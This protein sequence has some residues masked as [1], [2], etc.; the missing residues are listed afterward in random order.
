M[1]SEDQLH[2][3]QSDGD[4]GRIQRR[5]TLSLD[6]S[7]LSP[8]SELLARVFTA[9][10]TIKGL[11]DDNVFDSRTDGIHGFSD[12]QILASE[13]DLN[14]SIT[15]SDG[16]FNAVPPRKGRSRAAS[17]FRPP[18]RDQLYERN[19]HEWT[20]SGNNSQI[21]EFMRIKKINKRKSNDLYRASFAL[22]KNDNSHVVDINEMTTKTLP[23]STPTFLNRLNPFK[24][25]ESRKQSLTPDRLDIDR[26]P[27][28]RISPI[29]MQKRSIQN[30]TAKRRASVFSILSTTDDSNAE[31]LENTTIA[32]LI[33]ALEVMHTQAVTGND[34]LLE[35]ENFDNPKRKLGMV[36]LSAPMTNLPMINVFPP[37][38]PTKIRNRRGSIRPPSN[39]SSP[40]MGPSKKNLGRRQSTILDDLPSIRRSSFFQSPPIQP[41]PYSETPPNLAHRRF[42]V[43]P[44]QLNSPLPTGPR[45]TSLKR[46]LS[47]RT[48]SLTLDVPSNNKLTP[49]QG[50]TDDSGRMPTS[51][52]SN[53]NILLAPVNEL[54]L[55]TPSNQQGPSRLFDSKYKQN[56]R[57][58]ESK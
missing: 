26:S 54:H 32:D 14:M 51:P 2:H 16:S 15:Y 52:I 38:T 47:M 42:S 45:P 23:V 58:S 34:S 27:I 39:T 11:D 13:N 10:G 18:P 22:S 25:Q 17:D 28:D 36:G 43:R 24:R 31:V 7:R 30:S 48:T 35:S 40:F 55:N 46:R 53:R 12:S 29:S 4:I 8:P 33:R 41:P 49:R 5:Q 57:R 19:E 44:A 1:H 50:R 20:W 37:A 6:N 56:R 3:A 9:L 21:E